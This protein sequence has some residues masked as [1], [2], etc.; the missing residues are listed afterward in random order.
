[1]LRVL[2]AL[3]PS[4]SISSHQINQCYKCNNRYNLNFLSPLIKSTSVTSVT[5][6]TTLIS[7]LLSSNQPVLRVLQ[8]LRPSFSISSHQ[9]NQCYKRYDLHFLSLLIKSTSVTSVTT[10]IFYLFSSNQ[11]VLRVLLELQPSFSISSHQ[12]N[13]CYECY[14][15]YNLHFLSLLSLQNRICGGASKQSPDTK[16]FLDPNS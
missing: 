6:V 4:F 9:I 1:M 7:Y 15:R 3:Q 2:Q 14:M 11:P 8:A 13:L 10:F 12:I 16:K 5:S